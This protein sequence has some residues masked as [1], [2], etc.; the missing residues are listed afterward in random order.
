MNKTKPESKIM[1]DFLNNIRAEQD[2]QAKAIV[3]LIKLWDSQQVFNEML[4]DKL[5][6]LEKQE[7]I[8]NKYWSEFNPAIKPV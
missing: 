3:D 8:L 1:A 5:N 6:A 4:H 2:N 7:T